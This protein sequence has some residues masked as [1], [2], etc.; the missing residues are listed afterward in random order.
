MDTKIIET[1]IGAVLGLGALYAV[2]DFIA[3]KDTQEA[4]AESEAANKPDEAAEQ[5]EMSLYDICKKLHLDLDGDIIYMTNP[6][7]PSVMIKIYIN[8]KDDVFKVV[9]D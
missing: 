8:A 9:E 5:R 3:P 1:A 7:D 6:L 2:F 4:E